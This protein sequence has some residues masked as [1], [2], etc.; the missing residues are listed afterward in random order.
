MY[1][2]S[3]YLPFVFVNVGFGASVDVT[4]AQCLAEEVSMMQKR[5]TT[6]RQ[7]ISVEC[8]LNVFESDEVTDSSES[9]DYHYVLCV[10]EEGV[11]YVRDESRSDHLSLE[12]I[13]PGSTVLIELEELDTAD[14]LGCTV[15]SPWSTSGSPLYQA[16]SVTSVSGLELSEVAV[17]SAQ[18]MDL[19]MIVTIFSGTDNIWDEGELY[20]QVFETGASLND[21]FVHSSSGQLSVSS[22]MTKVVTVTLASDWASSWSSVTNCPYMDVMSEAL[23]AVEEQH[24]IDPNAYTYREIFMPSG[25]G[26]GWAGLASVGC[27]HPSRGLPRPG[28][29]IAWYNYKSI[30][31]RAHELGHNLGLLHAAAE[32]GGSFTEYGDYQ[33]MM[34]Y[35]A[36]YAPISYLPSARYQLG[37]LAEVSGEV[38]E[39]A[40]DSSS[41]VLLSSTSVELGV[42]GADAVAVMIPC[43]DCVPQT[44]TYVSNVGGSLWVTFR[45][46]ESSWADEVISSQFRQKVFVHLARW[47]ASVYY[48]GGTELWATLSEGETYDLPYTGFSV[49]FCELIDNT[50]R[51][52]ITQGEHNCDATTTATPTTA[53]PTTSTPTTAA[54]TTVA[55]TTSAPTTSGPTTVA[56]TTAAPTTAAPTTAAPT[57]APT[58]ATP[59]TS[60]PTTSAPTT[61]APTT[62]APT[63][64][65][66]TTRQPPRGKKGGGKQGGRR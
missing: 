4:V 26:C 38:I 47:Y 33:S 49:K 66:P 57:T 40:E 59:T 52:S 29:C 6:S 14:L 9:C 54:P 42:G 15:P 17:S 19:L 24:G 10:S 23:E 28:A 65:A 35:G 34:G 31:V 1:W 43:D 13:V 48:G 8:V 27:G 51:V 18:E 58:T 30:G 3:W 55:P 2:I 62:A 11:Y 53:A 5:Q 21:L 22:S 37:L 50:S 16:V 60:A 7:R 20:E 25:G 63:T 12:S 56:P 36:F 61:A 64:A 32:S 44:S 45:G 39:W 46:E 41:P